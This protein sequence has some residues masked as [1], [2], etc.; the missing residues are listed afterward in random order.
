MRRVLVVWMDGASE[1]FLCESIIYHSYGFLQFL[2]EGEVLAAVPY[3][4]IRYWK[5]TDA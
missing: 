2:S 5:A 3:V 1:E 4:N